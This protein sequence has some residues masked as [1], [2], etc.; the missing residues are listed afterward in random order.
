MSRRLHPAEA[1]LVG[2][3]RLA[4]ANVETVD[5]VE[6]G[7]VYA[8]V[9]TLVEDRIMHRPKILRR[10]SRVLRREATD[11]DVDPWIA[12]WRAAYD[13]LPPT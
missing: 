6:S 13:A 7:L 3:I 5:R 4:G 2:R 10:A 11:A 8:V 9:A 12:A 1:A